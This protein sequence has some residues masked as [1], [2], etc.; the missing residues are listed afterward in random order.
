[1][2]ADNKKG[3]QPAY[4]SNPTVS[5]DRHAVSA[6]LDASRVPGSAGLALPLAFSHNPPPLSP[7]GIGVSGPP[8]CSFLCPSL[9]AQPITM[10]MCFLQLFSRYHTKCTCTG[11][12]LLIS[13]HCSTADLMRG[14]FRPERAY[15]SP[16]D[17]VQMQALSC[18]A[19]GAWE[20]AG[21][22]PLLGH[23]CTL[24]SMPSEDSLLSRP[25][26]CGEK[27]CLM[28]VTRTAEGCQGPKT[29]RT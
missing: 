20:P 17:L 24:S 22:A 5:R 2:K 3:S 15:Q 18:R 6:D 11:N 16:G 23:D 9:P 12:T 28:A 26:R 10:H 13:A 25:G 19:P 1:M 8:R 14:R 27:P 7:T 4:P 29:K 21:H